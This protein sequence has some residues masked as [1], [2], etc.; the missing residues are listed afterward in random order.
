MEAYPHKHD[1]HP[2]LHSYLEERFPRAVASKEEKET[3]DVEP[4]GFEQ[5]GEKLGKAG[6]VV[7]A[8]WRERPLF[9]DDWLKHGARNDPHVAA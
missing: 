9:L 5:R 3:E 4:C 2:H 6:C 7:K 1:T 8:G